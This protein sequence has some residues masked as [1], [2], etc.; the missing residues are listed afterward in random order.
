[1]GLVQK[2]ENKIAKIKK[3]DISNEDKIKLIE[4]F[5]NVKVEAHC[6]G[7]KKRLIVTKRILLQIINHEVKKLQNEK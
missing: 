5:K 4:R 7:C 6:P 3:Q 2:I 1:M